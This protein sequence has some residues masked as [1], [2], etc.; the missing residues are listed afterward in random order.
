MGGFG[1]RNKT[2][3]VK[4][5]CELHTTSILT[6]VMGFLSMKSFGAVDPQGPCQEERLH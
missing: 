6:F 2:E 1:Y 4:L 3:R 5:C